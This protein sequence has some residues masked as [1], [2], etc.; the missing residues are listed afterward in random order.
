MS[1]TTCPPTCS[2]DM[3]VP[4][5]PVSDEK[6]LEKFWYGKGNLGKE[7]FHPQMTLSV[8][9]FCYLSITQDSILPNPVCLVRWHFMWQ[10][11]GKRPIQK[12]LRLMDMEDMGPVGLEAPWTKTPSSKR[13][14]NADQIIASLE[15]TPPPVVGH[16]TD[17]SHQKISKMFCFF[18]RLEKDFGVIMKN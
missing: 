7:K 15:A 13:P 16:Q 9:D 2:Q 10:V 14:R 18:F 12:A 3:D 17:P 1:H 6:A 11:K 8:L 5:P 4:M